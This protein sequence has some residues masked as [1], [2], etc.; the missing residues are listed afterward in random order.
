MSLV[1]FCC[2]CLNNDRKMTSIEE[3]WKTQYL[4]E[5][6]NEVKMPSQP[7]EP[8]QLC[9]ECDA[10]LMKFVKFK[11]QVTHSFSVL[12]EYSQ[13]NIEIQPVPPKLTLSHNIHNISFHPDSPIGEETV[14][15][16]KQEF[17]VK[18]KIEDNVSINSDHYDDDRPLTELKNKK[19]TKN[20]K[21][22]REIELYREVELN[23][24]ELE[25]ERRQ[26]AMKDDYVNAMFR[27]ESCIVSFPNAD[28]LS[29]HVKLKHELHATHKCNICSR[30]YSSEVSYNYH[31]NKH[32]RRY[33]CTSCSDKFSSKRAVVKH[34]EH[35]H[36]CGPEI[37]HTILKV[38][39]NSDTNDSSKQE[40]F[41]CE[42]CHKIFKWKTSLRKHLETHR[43]EMGQKRR[44][45]C[46]PCRLSFSTSA[47]LQKHVKTSSTHQIKLKLR[48]LQELE[49]LDEA[50]PSL[51]SSSVRR[52][53]QQ[54]ACPHCDKKFQWRGNLSRHI[55]S[56]KD[57]AN[58][59]L[60]CEPC[61]RTFS[62]IATYKQHMAISKKHVSESDY[63]HMCSDCGKR[64]AN[65]TQLKDHVDWEHLKNYTHT[66]KDCHKVFK[67]YTSLYLHKEVVHRK[68]GAGHLCDHCGKSYPNKSKLRCHIT[69]LHSG[70]SPYHCSIC[71]ARFS[72]HSCLSRHVRRAHPKRKK[73]E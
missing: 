36:C 31:A 45:Y 17:E 9:Y 72:W 12:C 43:I 44:P 48:K 29:D 49:P 16:I 41:P 56:H 10:L 24:E 37:P 40:A 52:S 2:G 8:L 54:Y 26:L 39:K 23:L 38:D 57:R 14:H 59:D 60:V 68:D 6:I 55:N 18:V 27:C 20:K 28:D 46:E 32:T 30:T 1:S 47:N 65:K 13:K 73:E 51:I 63:K 53:L 11:Q 35:A 71:P 4:G 25:E 67:S 7:S 15:E 70:T 3:F 62:S 50:T 66:C 5:I 64:F 61:N 69:A 33:E 58:G 21:K 22:K 19:K 34:Y 42:L